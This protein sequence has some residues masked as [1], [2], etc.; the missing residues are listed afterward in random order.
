MAKSQLPR[1]LM[2]AMRRSRATSG[3]GLAFCRSSDGPWA[4]PSERHGRGRW[5]G[6]ISRTDASLRAETR[7]EEKK[8]WKVHTEKM[9]AEHQHAKNLCREAEADAEKMRQKCSSLEYENHVEILL[10]TTVAAAGWTGGKPRR[11]ST[12]ADV[13]LRRV[14]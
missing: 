10:P 5:S 6:T 1:L 4:W 13:E 11:S 7:D 8:D 3:S 2:V 9:K 14:P 12:V